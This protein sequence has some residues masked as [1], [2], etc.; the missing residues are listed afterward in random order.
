MGSL[1]SLFLLGIVVAKVVFAILLV[2]AIVGVRYIPIAAWVFWKSC[3]LRAAH[4]RKGAS[5]R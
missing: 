2:L 5:S 3:G 4:S 1:T